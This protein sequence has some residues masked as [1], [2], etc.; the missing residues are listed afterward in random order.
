[1]P[2]RP[3]P[4][5]QS[6]TVFEALISPVISRIALGT[7]QLGMP[8]GIANT[9]GRPE[10][11]VAQQIVAECWQAGVRYFDTAQAYGDSEVVLGRVLRN[12]GV[13]NEARVVTKLSP[14]LQTESVEGILSSLR[15][16][17]AQLRLQRLWAVLLHR[18]DQLD[19]WYGTLGEAFEIARRH[20]LVEHIGVSVYSPQR[21]LEAL[22]IPG[23]DVLQVPAN[24]FDRRMRKAQVL[25][26][27]SA[28]NVTVFI[29]SIYLQGLALFNSRQAQETAPFAVSAVSAL[30]QFCNVNGIDQ[31]RFVFEYARHISSEAFRI[32]GA[33][34]KEQVVENIGLENEQPLDSALYRQWD[35]VW[36]DDVDELV[37]PSRWPTS[38][39]GN[40]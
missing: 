32:V 40:Q 16:S 21:A 12:L 1:M 20:G 24:L 14:T 34:T 31:K 4:E 2:L 15:L 26:K 36:P 23:L 11:E 35:K 28:K 17:L 13:A 33:E 25:E 29:R 19:Y 7:A 5:C 38:F 27:A 8:Y 22:H 39:R 37:N 18:E 10:I 3:L 6:S 9:A 30:E